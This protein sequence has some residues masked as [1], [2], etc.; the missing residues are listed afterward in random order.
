[1]E[2]R[3]VFLDYDGV[4]NTYINYDYGNGLERR[5]AWPKDNV[6]NNKRAV[7]ILNE[8]YETYPFDIVVSSTWRTAPNYKE[9]LYNGGLDPNIKIIGATPDLDWRWRDKEIQQWIDENNFTGSYVILDDEPYLFES[10]ETTNHHLILVSGDYGLSRKSL[11]RVIRSFNYQEAE[12][13]K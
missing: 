9:C 7:D 1:M 12:G 6:I 8:L 10:T 3:I 5:Y 11:K 2:G 4:V 13:P